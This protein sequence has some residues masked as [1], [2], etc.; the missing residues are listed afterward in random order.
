MNYREFSLNQ[1][2]YYALVCVVAIAF[3]T[4]LMKLGTSDMILFN[5]GFV[6]VTFACLFIGVICGV[7]WD[8]FNHKEDSK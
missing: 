6:S 1:I 8:K 3:G 2:S 5:I 4:E 7:N